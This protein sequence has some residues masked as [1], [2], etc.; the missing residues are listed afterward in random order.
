M[1]QRLAERQRCTPRIQINERAFLGRR[2]RRMWGFGAYH[3]RFLHRGRRPHF[4]PALCLLQEQEGLKGKG[5]FGMSQSKRGRFV[6]PVRA[7]LQGSGEDQ[8]H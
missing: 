4:R 1:P 7:G 5:G 8:F 2:R 3:A 6:S